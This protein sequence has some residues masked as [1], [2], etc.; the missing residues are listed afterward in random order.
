MFKSVLSALLLLVLN[1]ITHA[2]NV[3]RLEGISIQG[4]SEEP[5]VMY[6]TPWRPPPGTGRL[7]QPINSY[8]EQWMQSIDRDSFHREMRYA[9]RYA[10]KQPNQERIRQ[11]SNPPSLP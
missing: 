7:Y 5:N 1:S 6:V 9:E 2:D 3:V 4:N 10:P 8:R 11:L